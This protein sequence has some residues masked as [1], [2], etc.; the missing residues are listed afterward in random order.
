MSFHHRLNTKTIRLITNSSINGL[1]IGAGIC[2]TIQSEKYI[3][4]PLVILFPSVYSGY[5]SYKNK[6]KILEWIR[7]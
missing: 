7:K 4:I 1:L 5:H 6:D 3:H 2:Y